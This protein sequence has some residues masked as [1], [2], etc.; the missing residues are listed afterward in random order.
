[1]GESIVTARG[2]PVPAPVERDPN[3]G[4]LRAVLHGTYDLLWF[5]AMVVASPWWLTRSF[6]QPDFGSMVF[7]RLTFRLPKLGPTSANERLLI[8]GVSVGEVKAAHS[9]VRALADEHPDWEIVIS[10]T[11]H[12]GMQV[13]RKLYPG[14]TIVRFPIDVSPLVTRFLSRLR[15]TCVVLVELEIWP[16][17]LRA[18]NRAGIPVAVANGRIT[19][20]SFRRYRLFRHTL[21]QFNRMTLF[22]AQD[23]RYAERFRR[24]T[25]GPERVV[26]TGNVKVDALEVTPRPLEPELVRL[27]GG[28]PGQLV[29]LAGSTHEPEELWFVEACERALP[30]ARVI[31]VP[32]HPARTP[33]VVKALETRGPRPQ[34]LTEL[35]AGDAPDIGRPLLVDTIGE[36][37][38]LYLLADL[39]FVGGSLVP[40]GG[41]NVLEPAAR[42]RPVLHGPYVENFAAEVL[43]LSEARASRS[44]R[45]VDELARVLAELA[46]NP[47]E[48][49][50]MARAGALAVASQQGATRHTLDA[51]VERCRMG[52]HGAEAR[53]RQRPIMIC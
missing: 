34:L 36:L 9:L 16:N 25:G 43:L 50:R 1:L 11:T 44:V 33:Q 38:R 28:A 26:I 12:T 10:S 6:L 41:Q 52:S 24:L 53:G 17:F 47:A 5:V 21:P 3:P 51:L 13:A 40:H 39:V 30:D 23:E 29:V 2:E 7:E 27:A 45:D 18:A 20:E 4:F 32:R 22:C 46:A 19:E 48:R 49:E 15:P 37:D 35:R 42:A 14:R 8:H 31:L